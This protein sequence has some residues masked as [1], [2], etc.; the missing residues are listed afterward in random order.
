[1]ASVVDWAAMRRSMGALA[2][3]VLAACGGDGG[4]VT[5][6]CAEP[7]DE[8][9]DPAWI[10]H[11]LPDTP[12]PPYLTDPPTS[13]PH[14]ATTPPTGVQEEA[15]SRPL[16]VS[17]LEA[18]LTLVQYRPDDVSGASLAALERL[19]GEEVVVAPNER[20][21]DSVVATAWL[22]K[23]TCDGVDAE[24]LEDFA[25]DAAARSAAPAG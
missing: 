20:L 16:Q 4:A 22:L 14:L 17:I 15:L 1:M 19:A 21:P 10:T 18:G 25:E 3:L 7:V 11:V 13:G 23:M 2:L 5:G 6:S 9:L 24:A 12:E 8:E